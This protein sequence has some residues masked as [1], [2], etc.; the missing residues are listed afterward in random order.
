MIGNR[1]C[2]SRS[3]VSPLPCPRP[4]S[5]PPCGDSL[6]PY[7]TGRK[8]GQALIAER[9]Y[10]EACELYAQQASAAR[11]LIELGE[12]NNIPPALSMRPEF[13]MRLAWALDYTCMMK[14][15]QGQLGEAVKDNAE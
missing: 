2:A 9:R 5:E 6:V 4:R 11:R 12:E 15:E 10:A 13:D 1:L 3:V 14:L 8:A 7:G